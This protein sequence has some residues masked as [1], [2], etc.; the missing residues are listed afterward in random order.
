[1][2]YLTLSDLRGRGWTDAMVREY[3]GEPDATRPNPIYRSAA[4]VRLYLAERADAA[5]A[6]PEV[7]R[8]ES[9]RGRAA[10]N[11]HSGGRQ[12]ARGQGTLD[13]LPS[14]LITR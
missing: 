5:E 12:E 11:G 10:C 4:P 13:D 3:L 6:G 14:R 1:V 9:A 2:T 8:A 7:G